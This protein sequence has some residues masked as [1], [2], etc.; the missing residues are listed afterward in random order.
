M[1]EECDRGGFA[2]FGGYIGLGLC[3]FVFFGRFLLLFGDFFTLARRPLGFA[4]LVV[5]G[6][7]MTK[8]FPGTSV[9]ALPERLVPLRAAKLL[10]R[11]KRH[12]EMG[13]AIRLRETLKHMRAT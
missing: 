5:G 7:T 9:F 4:F 11:C 12:S 13:L 3:R 6:E 1:R 8:V 2:F 10:E